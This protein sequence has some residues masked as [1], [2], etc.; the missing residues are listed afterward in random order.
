MS[1]W[2]PSPT[3]LRSTPN[4]VSLGSMYHVLPTKKFPGSEL[5]RVSAINLLVSGKRLAGH[6]NNYKE[7]FS[8][9]VRAAPL[10]RLQENR[11]KS[12]ISDVGNS[13]RHLTRRVLPRVINDRPPRV[14]VRSVVR[15]ANP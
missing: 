13:T 11:F 15:V 7:S 14:Y 8:F 3:N 5:R 10:P 4:E 6:E 2:D 12:P 9:V 1:N